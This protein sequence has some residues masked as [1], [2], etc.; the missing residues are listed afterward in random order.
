MCTTMLAMSFIFRGPLNFHSPYVFKA[1]FWLAIGAGFGWP[2]SSLVGIPFVLE[3]LFLY[4]REISE[5]VIISWRRK[6]LV[7]L[8]FASGF[9]LLV[10][11]SFAIAEL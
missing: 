2:F 3:E 6:R 10:L 9:C 7:R 1:M 4:G 11:V 5:K 8:L